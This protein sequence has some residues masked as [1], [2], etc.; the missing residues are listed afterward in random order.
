MVIDI[1]LIDFIDIV[2]VA[3]ILFQLYKLIRGT[4]ALSIFIGIF[5]IYMFWLVVKALNMQLI[6]AL[7]GQVIGV[8]VIALIIVFQQEVRRFLLAIG[9]RYIARQKFSFRRFFTEV[10]EET[11]SPKEAEEIVRASES[12]A[13]KKTG[14]LIVLGRKSSLDIYSEGGEKIDA[15]ISA[16]LLESIFFKNSPL[17]DGAV[18]IE[19]GR[20]FA[21]RCPLPIT[22]NVAIPPR[23][24]MRHR[25][26]LGISEH[27]DA[28]VVVVSE[29]TGNITLAEG[30]VIRE[31]ITANELRQ[32]LLKEKI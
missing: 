11:G 20:I 23:L 31:N 14:A 30:G 22:D 16:Q 1:R 17:H 21:A 7:M 2:L 18:L 19:D 6:G 24:G 10:E 12:M 9:N 5:I 27:T 29:E 26:A 15:R 28:L 3:I 4:T 8:G 32:V 25:A 13:A